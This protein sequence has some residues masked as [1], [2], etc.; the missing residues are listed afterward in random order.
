MTSDLSL[1][2]LPGGAPSVIQLGH[3]HASEL[4]EE[5]VQQLSQLLR[6]TYR[7]LKEGFKVLAECSIARQASVDRVGESVCR[8]G[9]SISRHGASLGSFSTNVSGL[10]VSVRSFRESL[11]ASVTKVKH[12]NFT[13]A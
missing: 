12:S 3:K 7:V 1:E 5:D 4:T 10:E 6:E 9:K 2:H 8:L 13:S 11:T